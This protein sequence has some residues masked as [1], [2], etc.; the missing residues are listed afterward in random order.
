MPY[1]DCSLKIVDIPDDRGIINSTWGVAIGDSL[2]S[3]YCS[4]CN[5]I[6]KAN[7]PRQLMVRSSN[8]AD[9]FPCP[10]CI[11]MILKMVEN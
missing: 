11:Q 5:I 3:Y 4:F 7:F 6:W 2:L 10:G 9:Q 1:H 8:N